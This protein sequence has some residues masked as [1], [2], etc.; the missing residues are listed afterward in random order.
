MIKGGSKACPSHKG[1][2]TLK[3]NL[4]VG[5]SH[6]SILWSRDMKRT[7]HPN[8]SATAH[9]ITFTLGYRAAFAQGKREKKDVMQEGRCGAEWVE[10]NGDKTAEREAKAARPKK[11]RGGAGRPTRSCSRSARGGQEFLL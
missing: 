7:F 8:A 5:E 11:E 3:S 2:M 1:R 6:I 9:L 10:E 4:N